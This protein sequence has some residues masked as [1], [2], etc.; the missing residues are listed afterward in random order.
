MQ[1][2]IEL[3]SK[4]RSPVREFGRIQRKLEVHGDRFKADRVAQ[5]KQDTRDQLLAQFQDELRTL[6]RETRQILIATIPAPETPGQKPGHRE[7]TRELNWNT[8]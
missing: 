2:E 6:R 4:C 8:N 7:A 1:Q 5:I 3:S